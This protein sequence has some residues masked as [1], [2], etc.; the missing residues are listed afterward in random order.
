MKICGKLIIIFIGA[1]LA[2]ASSCLH[3]QI[4]LPPYQWK[5]PLVTFEIIGFFD[6][7]E[8]GAKSSKYSSTNLTNGNISEFFSFANYGTG[9]GTGF[10]INAKV[11]LN[12]KR[13]LLGYLSLGYEEIQGDDTLIYIS[14]N[15]LHGYPQP[16]NG[17]YSTYT[18]AGTSRIE[19]RNLMAGIGIEYKY[20]PEKPVSLYVSTDFNID[21]LY[22]FYLEEPYGA[23][24]YQIYY[25]IN[26]AVRFGWSI[27][28]GV[29][30][31]VTNGMGFLVGIKYHISNLFGRSSSATTDNTMNLLDAAAPNLNSNLNKDRV[32]GIL[33][34]FL[35]FSTSLGFKK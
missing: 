23:N 28:T 20:K 8:Q 11:A 7:P 18:G 17:T 10:N 29:Q 1:I 34:P 33:Q 15:G 24:F 14:P 9:L 19:I 13:N 6:I 25:N 32:I 26:G 30:L 21:Y 31:R 22:G 27:C 3:S 4:S 12:K 2:C 5:A 16:G 35:G